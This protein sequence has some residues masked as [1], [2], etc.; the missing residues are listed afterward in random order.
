MCYLFIGWI[1]INP[2]NKHDKFDADEDGRV[3]DNDSNDDD[4]SEQD[5]DDKN[6]H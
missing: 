6:Y 4:N 1:W 5:N 3:D 2:Q